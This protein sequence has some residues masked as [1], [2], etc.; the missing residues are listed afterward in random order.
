MDNWVKYK[1]QRNKSKKKKLKEDKKNFFVNSFKAKNAKWKFLKQ[2]NGTCK[3]NPP[4]NI[5]QGV[6]IFKSKNNCPIG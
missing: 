3:S 1:N 2:C 5:T 4:S 6:P